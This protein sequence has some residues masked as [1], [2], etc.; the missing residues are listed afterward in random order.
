MDYN[1]E[2]DLNRDNDFFPEVGINESSSRDISSTTRTNYDSND[3][4]RNLLS[5]SYLDNWHLHFDELKKYKQKI[6]HTV[7]PTDYEDETL[8]DWCRKQR[9]LNSNGII[10][11]EHKKQLDSIDFYW[12]NLVDWNSEIVWNENYEQFKEYYLRFKTFR[13]S[14]K[15]FRKLAVW[16][17][18]TRMDY[19]KGLM[20][21]S[22][23][24][25]MNDLD[26]TWKVASKEINDDIWFE[27]LMLLVEYKEHN[28]HCNVPQTEP[29]IGRWLNDQRTDKKRGKLN[30]E[31]EDLLESTG[32]IWDIG[33]YNFQ[34][35]ID[36]LT[37]YKQRFGNYDVPLD[38]EEDTQLGNFVYR[39]QTRGTTPERTRI[40]E[41][42]DFNWEKK[43]TKTVKVKST[44][45]TKEWQ[46]NVEKVKAYHISGIDVNNI[47]KE[48]TDL[49]EIKS[50]ILSQ[51]QRFRTSEFKE[52]QIKLLLEAGV[53][54]E[55]VSKQEQRW[56]HFYE[57][58]TLFK[59]EHGHCKV[60]MTFDEEFGGWVS[61]QRMSYKNKTLDQYKIDKLNELDFEW[62]TGKN[63]KN[64]SLKAKI[65][66][67]VI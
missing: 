5:Q 4:E 47:P 57:L 46:A 45:I 27:K 11:I 48:A 33:E 12:R 3:T 35:M 20:L 17:V 9:N 13:V 7:V 32:V 56:N 39:L 58:L 1:Q 66:E 22:Q 43:Y 50:W 63:T 16:I 42:L 38:F 34:L 51:Q 8:F 19:H 37:K 53:T 21:D 31:R 14:R 64:Q 26:P 67:G 60:T 52:K 2:D 15:H 6:G 36:R 55:K 18:N 61:T 40:L 44:H 62:V 30:S 54:L 65:T 59:Q 23:I 24:K 10:P 28:G 25:K 41:D 49:K 29:N